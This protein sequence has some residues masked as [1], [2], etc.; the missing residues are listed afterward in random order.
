MIKSI[1]RYYNSPL[2]KRERQSVLLYG[3]IMVSG[4][5]RPA[6]RERSPE[7]LPARNL[8]PSGL[9]QLEKDRIDTQPLGTRVLYYVLHGHLRTVVL[10]FYEILYML[11]VE[12]F[13]VGGHDMINFLKRDCR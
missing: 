9:L 1:W 11:D 4:S 7:R 13:I 8:Q 5:G 12:G 2:K 3:F 6:H 10:G